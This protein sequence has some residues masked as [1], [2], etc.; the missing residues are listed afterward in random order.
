MKEELKKAKDEAKR[1][2]AEV[3]AAKAKPLVATDGGGKKICFHFRDHG[4]CPKGDRCPWFHDKELRKRVL[5]EAKQKSDSTLATKGGKGK[6]RGKGKGKGGGKSKDKDGRKFCPFFQR[7]GSCKK[8][9]QC[10]MV[11]ALPAASSTS[12][13]N[14]QAQGQGNVPAAWLERTVGQFV[15]GESFCEFFGG[16]CERA[17][18]GAE[19]QRGAASAPAADKKQP[20]TTLDQI[21][22]DWFH[23]V[24]NERGGYQYTYTEHHACVG[25]VCRNDA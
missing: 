20:F 9:A 4:S 22:S 15:G 17:E 13:G 10:D 1:A 21:P 11:H 2:K 24:E 3:A 23:V 8:G 6:G 7:N 25:Q 14:D 19:E 5:A 16:D 12:A 18:P